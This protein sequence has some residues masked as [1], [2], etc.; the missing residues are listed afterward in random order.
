[1]IS[2]LLAKTAML[3]RAEGIDDIDAAI[4][5]VIETTD[6]DVSDEERKQ[7]RET[8]QSGWLE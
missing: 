4:E 8:L 5:A 2:D 6:R 7:F 3:D 1:M